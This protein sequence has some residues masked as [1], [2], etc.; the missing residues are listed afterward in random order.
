[1]QESAAA[2][3]FPPNVNRYL[4]EDLCMREVL[5]RPGCLSFSLS[6]F[7]VPAPAEASTEAPESK[8]AAVVEKKG[9][10]RDKELVGSIPKVRRMFFV[11]FFLPLLFLSSTFPTS[12]HSPLR[13]AGRPNRGHTGAGGWIDPLLRYTCGK[14]KDPARFSP[15]L[16]TVH[17]NRAYSHVPPW[18]RD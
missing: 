10:A 9:K 5:I 7:L 6:S 3:S 13:L 16:G 1:M 18:G 15:L 2:V 17:G 8:V 4:D 12:P 11:F 14:R